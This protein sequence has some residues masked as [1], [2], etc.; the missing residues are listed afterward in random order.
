MTRRAQKQTSNRYCL[1][2]RETSLE[3]DPNVWKDNEMKATPMVV[4][5]W[6]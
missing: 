2:L 5:Q 3:I 6:L 1:Q 4:K